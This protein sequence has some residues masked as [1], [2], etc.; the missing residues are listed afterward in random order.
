L[1]KSWPTFDNGACSFFDRHFKAVP[2]KGLPP[3]PKSV[4][5][6]M[7]ISPH[8]DIKYPIIGLCIAQFHI[9]SLRRHKGIP[10]AKRVNTGLRQTAIIRKTHDYHIAGCLAASRASIASLS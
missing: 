3:L 2:S 6:D 7:L 9:L 4:R 8:F 5:V 10:S 1:R